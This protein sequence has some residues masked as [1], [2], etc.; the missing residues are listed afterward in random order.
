MVTVLVGLT[1]KVVSAKAGENSQSVRPLALVFKDPD[2][3][4]HE[5]GS[6]G[7]SEAVQ[8][9]AI[10][11][12]YDARLITAEEFT[13]AVLRNVKIWFQP[14]GR[15]KHQAEL[16]PP[17][18]K[19]AIKSYVQN[20][21]SYIGFCAGG[22]LAT[23]KFG[24]E[25]KKGTFEADGIGLLPGKSFLYEKFDADLTP[26]RT[27]VVTRTIWNGVGRHVFWDL[28]PYFLPET[29]RAGRVLAYY[30]DPKT[31]E[32]NLD[33]AM[34]ITA[35]VGLGKV[36]ITAVHPEAPQDWYDYYGLSDPDGLDYS[37]VKQLIDAVQ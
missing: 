14:G 23:E 29:S 6:T 5:Y 34:T 24:W 15:A 7:C 10:R 11:Y 36:G 21:G 35:R 20:G 37:L 8:Q 26:D 25:T 28:G 31:G 2:I 19:A 12:G 1:L 3:C 27:G 13:P 30:L 16:M 9:V 22:F 33:E 32:Q 18:M 4:K 17:E